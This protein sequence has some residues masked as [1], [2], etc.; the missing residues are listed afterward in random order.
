MFFCDHSSLIS[1]YSVSM[2]TYW[3]HSFFLIYQQEVQVRE[4]H[5][6]LKIMATVA[7][8]RLQRIWNEDWSKTKKQNNEKLSLRMAD[9]FLSF[10]HNN[11]KCK[12]KT[13]HQK[14][15]RNGLPAEVWG[16]TSQTSFQARSW[17]ICLTC[18][19]I[20]QTMVQKL[21]T[22]KWE[23]IGCRIWRVNRRHF[24]FTSGEVNSFIFIR[25]YLSAIYFENH[26]W[27]KICKH[28]NSSFL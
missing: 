19:N 5:A 21:N 10:N 14:A 16:V 22:K 9:K 3:I 23:K 13:T 11:I 12:R 24:P 28:Q 27:S 7:N 18:C 15:V 17:R 1:M 25:F 20:R 8:V 6:S 2:I 26:R 4:S